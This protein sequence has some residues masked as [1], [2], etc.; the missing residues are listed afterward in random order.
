MKEIFKC[1]HCGHDTFEDKGAISFA[2]IYFHGL[3]CV[4]CKNI[5]L[6]QQNC[7]ET[8]DVLVKFDKNSTKNELISNNFN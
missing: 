5:S 4:K 8:S 3:E 2:N 7:N 6:L 1:K